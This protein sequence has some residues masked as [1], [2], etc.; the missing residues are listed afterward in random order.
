MQRIRNK[1]ALFD[2]LPEGNLKRLQL[3][4]LNERIT[5]LGASPELLTRE[6]MING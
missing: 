3:A 6:D 4:R 2:D 1:I 5:E